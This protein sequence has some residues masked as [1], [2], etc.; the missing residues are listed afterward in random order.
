MIRVKQLAEYNEALEEEAKRIKTK[1]SESPNGSIVRMKPSG[2]TYNPSPI[3]DANP[4]ENNTTKK[5][6]FTNPSWNEKTSTHQISQTRDDN[7]SEAGSETSN[8]TIR[9]GIQIIKDHAPKNVYQPSLRGHAAGQGRGHQEA[10]TNAVPSKGYGKP[11]APTRVAGWGMTHSQGVARNKGGL[12][13]GQGL[14]DIPS[15][16]PRR[17]FDQTS[18]TE[19][20]VLIPSVYSEADYDQYGEDEDASNVS[21]GNQTFHN[22]SNHGARDHYRNPGQ[23][24]RAEGRR[25]NQG[26]GLP[27]RG[28]EQKDDGRQPPNDRGNQPPHQRGRRDNFG[29]YP[30]QRNDDREPYRPNVPFKD[31]KLSKY[32]GKIPWRAY[33]VKLMHMARKYNWDDDTKLAKLVEALDDKA[34]TFFSNLP[35]ETQGNF[36]IVRKKMNNRFIPSRA[37]YYCT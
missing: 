9:R 31:P 18:H 17:P 10:A 27:P 19:G 13:Q 22:E 37:F 26:Q 29:R 12:H 28:R 3:I 1:V 30:P 2:A 36:E 32:D 8:G 16:S 5:F 24:H 11:P 35:P 20:D 7:M 34:L 21:Q 6:Q 33:E 4:L 14:N 15:S 23:D 25:G